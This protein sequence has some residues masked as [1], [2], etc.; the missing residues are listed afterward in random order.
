MGKEKK[1]NKKKDSLL[2]K[3]NKKGRHVMHVLNFF[4]VF[5]YP[6]N[7]FFYPYKMH[8]YTKVGTAR[9]GREFISLPRI[10]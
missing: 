2:I 7:A 9:R 5:L 6:W 3:A 4:R 1:K 8:G 10:R